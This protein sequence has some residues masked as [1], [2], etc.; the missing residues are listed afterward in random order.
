MMSL[1]SVQTSRSALIFTIEARQ[2]AEG[3]GQ[4]AEEKRI[5]VS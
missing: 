2:R 3:R 4:K 5:L 1:H